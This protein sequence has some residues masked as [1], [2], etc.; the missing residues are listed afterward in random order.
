MI[1]C[2]E[3]TRKE[4]KEM[5]SVVQAQD[6]HFETVY[7]LTNNND[8]E[9]VLSPYG[10]RLLAIKV[11][12]TEGVRDIV[13]SPVDLAGQKAARYFGATIGPVAG[14]ISQ[15]YFEIDGEKFV[16]ETNNNEHTLHSGSNGFDNRVWLA[17]TYEK[18]GEV[19]VIFSLTHE[20]GEDGFPGKVQAKVTYSLDNADNLTIRYDATTDKPTLYNPTNHGYYNLTGSESNPINSHFLQVNAK[21]VATTNPDVT[22]TGTKTAVEGTKFDFRELKTIGETQLDDPFMLTHEADFDLVLVSPDEKVRLQITTDAPGVVIY[23][24]G[25]HE[26]GTLMKNGAMAV[27]GAIAI[28]TQGIPGAEKFAQYGDITLRPEQAFHSATTYHI[29]YLQV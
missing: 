19:G 16:T 17:E 23:T 24:T 22:T 29:D 7:R 27:R 1:G 18:D 5:L 8:L 12:L 25:T 11:P 14:R 20:D 10:A 15:S 21:E 2:R 3:F 9:V 6:Q 13:A 26:E 28:E 4:G